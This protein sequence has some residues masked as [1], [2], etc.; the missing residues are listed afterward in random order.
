MF[1]KLHEISLTYL[2]SKEEDERRIDIYNRFIFPG[3]S[4]YFFNDLPLLNKLWFST[5]RNVPASASE[6]RFSVF[7]VNIVASRMR[8]GES[9]WRDCESI[10][11]LQ[12]R[13][14]NNATFYRNPFG[15]LADVIRG[16]MLP[17]LQRI[18]GFFVE[19]PLVEQLNDLVEGGFL[20]NLKRLDFL[21]SPTNANSISA[22]TNGRLNPFIHCLTLHPCECSSNGP[23]S[24]FLLAVHG[25]VFPNLKDLYIFRIKQFTWQMFLALLPLPNTHKHLRTLR[26]VWIGKKTSEETLQGV[27]ALFPGAEVRRYRQ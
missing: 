14:M 18:E 2:A 10:S 6:E 13:N 11:I 16:G 27:R 22:W 21:V 19:K 8:R 23:T 9:R 5:G 20:P 25:G 1:P 7:M 12:V 4:P 3:T 15:L 17:K 24:R 26:H